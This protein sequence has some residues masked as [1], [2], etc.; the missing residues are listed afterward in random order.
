[1]VVQFGFFLFAKIAFFSQKK[2]VPKQDTFF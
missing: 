2:K 1:M